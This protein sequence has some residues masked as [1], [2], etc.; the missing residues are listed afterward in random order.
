MSSSTS[1]TSNT[2]NTSSTQNA[3]ASSATQ[4]TQRSGTAQSP[5]APQ[6][7]QAT[8]VMPHATAGGG[9]RPSPRDGSLR[10][11]RERVRVPGWWPLP[12]CLA[13]GALAGAVY[14]VVTVPQYSATSYIVVSSSKH[15]DSAGALGYAQAYG[16]IAADP[17]VLG[18]AEASAGLP[19]G[20]LR[21]AVKAS[22]S[23]DAPMI[24]ITGTADRAVPA[25]EHADAVAQALA[26][27]AKRSAKKTGAKLTV[28]SHAVAP[29][30]AVSPSTPIAISVGGCAGALVGGL[31]LLARPRQRRGGAPVETA[32]V[33]GPSHGDETGP[34][35]SEFG[36]ESGNNPAE[37]TR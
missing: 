5:Q 29:A 26:D 25:A 27:T 31:V 14:G 20:A 3:S 1:G 21:G 8:Q 33:P 18:A 17:V 4:K 28:L 11:R 10:P 2:S 35:G 36:S 22:T 23:P 37:M 32:A 19:S 30:S 15:A 34:D 6:A 13:L 24:E 9:P 12:L 7:T 16:K